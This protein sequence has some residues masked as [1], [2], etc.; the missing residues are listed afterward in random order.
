MFNGKTHYFDRV[1][2]KSAN[3]ETDLPE[4]KS[5]YNIPVLSHD[6]LYKTTL[7]HSKPVSQSPRFWCLSKSPSQGHGHHFS[8]QLHSPWDRSAKQ[9]GKATTNPRHPWWNPFFCCRIIMSNLHYGWINLW[10]APFGG[11]NP[12]CLNSYSLFLAF[13]SKL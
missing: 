2:F 8:P 4:G 10:K 1:I 7:N 9:N 12:Y 5:V 11:V 13:S 6:H 3:C